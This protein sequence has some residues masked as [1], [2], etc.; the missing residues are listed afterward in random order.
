VVTQ[1]AHY[2]RKK[3]ETIARSQIGEE[4]ANSFTLVLVRLAACSL[5]VEHHCEREE[6][7]EKQFQKKPSFKY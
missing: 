7:Q 5:V 4:E 1:S 3:N 6:K 2:Q